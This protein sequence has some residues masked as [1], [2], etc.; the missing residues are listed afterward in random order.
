MKIVQPFSSSL[1]GGVFGKINQIQ[2]IQDISRKDGHTKTQQNKL[3][4]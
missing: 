4:F 1:P 2:C 3:K